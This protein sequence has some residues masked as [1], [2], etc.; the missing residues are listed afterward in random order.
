MSK[1]EEQHEKVVDELLKLL[2]VWNEKEIRKY[3]KYL[4]SFDEFAIDFM[5]MVKEK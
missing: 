3:P 4:P 5:D 1:F 2:E